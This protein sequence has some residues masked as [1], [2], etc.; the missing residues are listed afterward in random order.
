[1]TT[2]GDLPDELA[3][4][5]RLATR[6]LDRLFQVLWKDGPTDELVAELLRV[7]RLGIFTAADTTARLQHQDLHPG[8][9]HPQVLVDFAEQ[10]A[11]TRSMFVKDRAVEVLS[12]ATKAQVSPYARLAAQVLVT[13]AARKGTQAGGIVGDATHKQFVRIRDA[14]EPRG[15]S[16]LEGSIRPVDG[17]WTIA[18]IEVDGP[19]DERLPPSEVFWCGHICRYLRLNPAVS[20]AGPMPAYESSNEVT[21]PIDQL[22]MP[23]NRM[24]LD[25]PVKE[26]LE[27]L[28]TYLQQAYPSARPT[29]MVT[30]PTDQQW[31]A[32]KATLGIPA[33]EEATAVYVRSAD[34]I[35]FGPSATQLLDH[36]DVRGRLA[37]LRYALH[38]WFHPMRTDDGRVY[39][40]EEGGAEL[41]AD[42]ITRT[43]TGVDGAL[44]RIQPY[45]G[46][47][48]GVTALGEAVSGPDRALYWILE[49]RK[50]PDMHAWFEQEM[51]GIGM[52]PE[53]IQT[54]MDYDVRTGGSWLQLVNQA[55]KRRGT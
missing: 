15:H 41:F 51:K 27:R 46:F 49:S 54:L 19:G 2:W 44:R 53:D 26:R 32:I 45:S 14:R 17:T 24:Y 20:S 37:G 10:L 5:Q 50:A 7:A 48:K 11:F 30:A 31:L 55:L 42:R 8:L 40:L 6:D 4:Q 21:T 3:R 34:L 36:Q 28:Q 22:P 43:L 18:G 29:D 9:P 52:Q 23:S 38:E 35:A 33:D 13:D 16:H 12:T 39:A 47:A 25:G 1:M